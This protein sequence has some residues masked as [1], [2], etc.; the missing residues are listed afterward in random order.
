MKIIQRV[1]FKYLTVVLVMVAV[2]V[3]S[4]AL[5]AGASEKKIP[6]DL[7]KYYT[8]ISVSEGDTLWKIA[9]EYCDTNYTSYADYISEIKAIND[10][11]SD[12]LYAGGSITVYY[13]SR[14]YK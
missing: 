9:G 1:N 10:M 12:K 6:S 2:I 5:N 11:K 3:V 7:Y 14:E 13:Y 4:M 8:T